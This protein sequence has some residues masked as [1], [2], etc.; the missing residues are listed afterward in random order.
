ML[1]EPLNDGASVS[2]MLLIMVAGV[3]GKVALAGVYIAGDARCET[4]SLGP[5]VAYCLE[6]KVAD[7]GDRA[8]GL[9]PSVVAGSSFSNPRPTG[10]GAS[11]SSGGGVGVLGGMGRGMFEA[12]AGAKERQIKGMSVLDRTHVDR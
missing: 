4:E 5:S 11:F 9:K 1:S 3:Y 10:C 6:G 2:V 7:M 12:M 8:F